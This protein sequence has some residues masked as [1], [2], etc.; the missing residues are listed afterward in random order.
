MNFSPS[1]D[2]RPEV[3]MVPMVD[4]ILQLVIFFM[5][6]TTFAVSSGLDVKLPQ[7]KAQDVREPATLT[8]TLTKENKLYLDQSPV[9]LEE[10]PAVLAQKKA[11]A[12]RESM[13]IIR[14]DREVTHGQV[15]HVM[16][17]AKSA[18]IGHLAIATEPIK[19]P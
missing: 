14:A 4:I 13:V 18:G 8:L 9:T 6:T 17:L 7:T 11:P 3:N 16:D 5:V 12:G 15:V 19:Q 2:P 10:L 1:E